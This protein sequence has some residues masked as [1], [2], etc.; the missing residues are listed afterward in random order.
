M[1][2]PIAPG[3]YGI[4]AVH[5]QIGF[6]VT[7]LGISIIRGTFDRFFGEL[8][9][10]DDLAATVVVVEAEVASINSGS[11]DRDASVLGPDFLDATAHPDMRFRSSSIVEEGGSY[12]MTSDLTIK[13]I[14][15][16]VKLNVTFNG[17]SNFP[18]DDS[19]H[20]GF[21]AAGIISRS[22]FG[23]SAL[24]PLVSDDVTLSIDAQF[25]LPKADSR[26]E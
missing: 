17:S 3:S 9:V 25:V 1:A 14:T 19:T 5:S 18:V 7:H 4:D 16:P 12:T 13:G 23:V 6:A 20:F 10:G 11:R 24:V 21:T 26:S 15:H 22:S 8:H 2:L